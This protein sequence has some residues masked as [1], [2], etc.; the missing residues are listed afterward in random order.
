MDL[1][2][3]HFEPNYMKIFWWLLA[4]TLF[5]VAIIYLHIPKIYLSAAL[6]LTALIKALLVAMNF[7]HLRFERWTL[8]A[9]VALPMLLI[10]D[11]L[12]AL[13]PDIGH[14]PFSF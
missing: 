1:E 11:L 7:M 14:L 8:I 5:E 2:Q 3:T 10:L 13:M 9:V 12:L 4:L 6:I